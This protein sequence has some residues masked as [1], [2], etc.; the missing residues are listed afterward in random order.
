M[1]YSLPG[2]SLHG[3][4]PD[5]N[6]AVGCHVLL[7]GTFPTQGS[8]PALPHCR[9]ILYH[10]SYQGTAKEVHVWLPFESQSLGSSMLL[11]L[12]SCFSCAQLFATLWTMPARFF[13]P[14]DSPDKKAGVDCHAL[15]QGNLPNPGI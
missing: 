5:K 4:S 1:D 14:W 7:Q 10:L 15:L 11:Q 13:C 12:L 8:N 2:S 9:Q 3:D 6:T